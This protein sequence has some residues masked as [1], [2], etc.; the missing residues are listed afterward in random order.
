[1]PAYYSHV[2]SGLA[3]LLFVIIPGSAFSSLAVFGVL[4][5]N[6]EVYG[7][8]GQPCY[9]L[10]V[11]CDVTGSWFPWRWCQSKKPFP[12]ALPLWERSSEDTSRT[13]SALTGS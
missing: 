2:I 3:C 11:F 4:L 10:T 5:L 8:I 12:S 6:R 9:G 13:A 7:D 1:M